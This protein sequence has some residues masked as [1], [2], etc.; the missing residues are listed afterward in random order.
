MFRLKKN[1]DGSVERYKACVV[2]QGFSQR[3][4]FDYFES[5]APTMRQATICTIL[6]LAAINDW[7]LRTIDISHIF[8]NGDLDVPVYMKQPESKPGQVCLL[9]RALYGLK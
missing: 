6:A 7:D 5:Y 4:G 1:A 9:K 3:P 8:T 2:A